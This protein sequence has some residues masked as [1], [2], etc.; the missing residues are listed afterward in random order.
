MNKPVKNIVVV[1]G[2]SA[3]WIAAGTIAAKHLNDTNYISVTLIESPNIAT[4]G[5][6]EGTWPTMRATL[7]RM[8]IS[9][10]EFFRECDV[11]FKQGAKFSKWATGED[12]DF[13]YHPLVLPQGFLDENLAP[14]WLED[15]NG[16]S[17]ADAVC[18][19]S[20]LCESHRAPKQITT[21]EYAAVENYAYHLDAGKFADLL[22]R[23]AVGSLGVKHILDDVESLKTHENGDIKALLTRGS[24]EIEGDL[25]I[26][27]SGFSSLLIGEHYKVPFISKKDILFI[28]TALA[29][30]VPYESADT[31]I[32]SHTISTAQKAGWIWDIGLSSRRGTGHVYASDYM[33]QA[34]AEAILRDYLRPDTPDIDQYDIRKIDI[35]PGHREKFWVNNCVAVGMAA[36]FL[37]PLEASALVLI[38]MASI[39]I[40]DNLPVNREVMDIIAKRYNKTFRYRWDRIID[41]LK[42]HYILSQRTDS[43]FWIDNRDP[44]TIPES[45]QELMALWQYQPPW[46]DDFTQKDEV[47]PSAS[48][49]YVLYGMGFKTANCDIWHS[50]SSKTSAQK[51]FQA[52]QKRMQKLIAA[53]PTNR[54]LLRKIQ[55][56]GM[57]KV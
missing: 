7:K 43:A 5:V 10:T 27:C 45:L 47:F 6:G 32:A 12:D 49:Q 14:H 16:K 30:Q 38:E 36:G 46:H 17:F 50:P 41:F 21:P 34:E 2:G 25:F 8:G 9:E 53:L 23:H 20:Y 24:G 42:L 52:N 54:E 19:Q 37:E 13:Y 18:A 57:Q 44:A 35:N 4:V 28:D 1:G 48:Y 55:Q 33:E 3:G 22:K 51:H 56:Y 11:S 26:D 39:M 29:V 15:G 40:A 31:P